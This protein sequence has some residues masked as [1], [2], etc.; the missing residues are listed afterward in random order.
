MLFS[1]CGWVV[2][3]FTSTKFENQSDISAAVGCVLS[4]YPPSIAHPS[5]FLQSLHSRPNIQ[6]LRPFLPRQRLRRHDHRYPLPTPLRS[7]QR[8]SPHLRIP[9]YGRRIV[10]LLVWLPNCAAAHLRFNWVD[11]RFGDLVGLCAPYTVE[12][13]AGWRVQFIIPRAR[14][15]H[16][17]CFCCWSGW[18][19]SEFDV[20]L[21]CCFFFPLALLSIL[22][23]FVRPSVVSGLA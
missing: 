11:G 6:S 20:S 22:G 3:H 17:S 16:R 14:G 9:N 15:G 21:L 7:R 8:R 1:C 2:N 10:F 13:E 18:I 12:K 4:C 5:N 23:V 19:G